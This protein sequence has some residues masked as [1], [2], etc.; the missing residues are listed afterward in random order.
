M[1]SNLLLLGEVAKNVEM[2][3]KVFWG[4]TWVCIISLVGITLT[5]LYFMARY[6][7][8]GEEIGADGLCRGHRCWGNCGDE[9]H[10]QTKHLEQSAHPI[11]L[12]IDF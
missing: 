2:V 10:R 1:S 6:R 4:V 8:R 5:M 3:D 7:R 9:P 12:T 11:S